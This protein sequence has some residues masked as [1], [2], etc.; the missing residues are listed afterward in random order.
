MMLKQFLLVSG[1]IIA[2]LAGVTISVK[3]DIFFGMTAW[4]VI[5]ILVDIRY[6]TDKE[7]PHANATAQTR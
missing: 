7:T 6:Q 5:Y 2:L 3:H 4:Y 1:N